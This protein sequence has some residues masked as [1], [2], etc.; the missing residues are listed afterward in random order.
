MLR[1]EG[2]QQWISNELSELGQMKFTYKDKE[3]PMRYVSSL[4]G[5]M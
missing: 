4:T 3:D 5:D 2:P 1:R